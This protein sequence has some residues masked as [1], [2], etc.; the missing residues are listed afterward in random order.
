MLY[1]ISAP[2]GGGKTSLVRA[3]TA[4]V[5]NLVISVSYTTRPL[6]SGEINGVNYH[7]VSVTEFKAMIQQDKF[8]E[9]ATVFDHLYGTSKEI[10]LEKKPNQ[11]VILE[12]DWQGAQQIRQLF[13]EKNYISIFIV[14]PSF[15]ILHARLT[16][17]A[18]DQAQVI[19]QRMQA[20]KSECSHLLE[21]DYCVINDSF[22]HAVR[23][24]EIIIQSQRLRADLQQKKYQQLMRDIPVTSV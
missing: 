21:F 14:P 1:I 13:P 12:I 9:Y 22:E 8:L 16:E 6:R 17:R 10:L 5:D 23:D 19:E 4:K 11:D 7:F 2:S 18:Q 3:L 20:A 24:L 15:E